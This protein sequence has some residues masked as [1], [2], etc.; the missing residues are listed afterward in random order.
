MKNLARNYQFIKT[1]LNI[2]TENE[3][4]DAIYIYSRMG[5]SSSKIYELI[6]LNQY[7]YR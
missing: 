6:Y 5:Y 7:R 3:I 2:K 1:E 4:R